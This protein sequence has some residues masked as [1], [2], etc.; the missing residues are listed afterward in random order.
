M[1]LG[2]HMP[3]AGGIWHALVLGRSIRCECV[4]LFLKNNLRWTAKP[5]SANTI[6]RFEQERACSGFSHVFA[7]AGYLI[8]LAGP[9][10][11][12]RDRSIAALVNE[13][14]LAAMLQLPFIVLHP[15]AH[16]GIGEARGINQVIAGLNEAFRITSHLDVRIALETTAGQGTSIGYKLEHLAEIFN[17]TAYPDRLALCIDTAH[18]F[19]A[20]YDIRTSAV[21]GNVLQQINS[22]IGL[23]RLVA[24]H[25]N[26]SKAGLGSRIDRHAHIGSGS[27]GKR[28]F[29][30]IV[31]EPRFKNHPACIET[32]KSN[33]L[34]EDIQN[35]ALLRSLMKSR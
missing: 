16:L 25:L 7:H 22:L 13:I 9:N 30:H 31:N 5:Y 29:K 21:W 17:K 8:N 28:A 24:I 18:L 33:G 26:D 6:K 15:G 11:P 3:I 34:H 27:L 35:L 20:G 14:E 2:A 23:D 19:A 12:K 4:Q 10:S 32:P 1:K